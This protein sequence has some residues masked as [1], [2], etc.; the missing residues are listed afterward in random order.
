MP[1]K[2]TKARVLNQEVAKKKESDGIS[3]SDFANGAF[4]GSM[5]GGSA[6]LAMKSLEKLYDE[7]SRNDTQG[8]TGVVA[9]VFGLATTFSYTSYLYYKSQGVDFES[10]KAL[11]GQKGPGGRRKNRAL[12][13][14]VEADERRAMRRIRQ[15]RFPG[16]VWDSVKVG[17]EMAADRVVKA[18]GDLR[19]SVVATGRYVGDFVLDQIDDAGEGVRFTR[20]SSV[21]AAGKVAD[22]LTDSVKTLRDSFSKAGD[23]HSVEGIEERVVKGDAFQKELSELDKI[24]QDMVARVKESNE[25]ASALEARLLE[26]QDAIGG[27]V[28]Q[29]TEDEMRAEVAILRAELEKSAERLR[30]AR[31]EKRFFEEK[32]KGLKGQQEPAEEVDATNV[33]GGEARPGKDAGVQVGGFDEIAAE[34]EVEA[35]AA[36]R[37]EN[38]ELRAKLAVAKA[39]KVA[40]ELENEELWRLSAQGSAR[41]DEERQVLTGDNERLRAKVEELQ[42]EVEASRRDQNSAFAERDAFRAQYREAEAAKERAEERV[43]EVEEALRNTTVDLRRVEGE[44]SELRDRTAPARSIVSPDRKRGGR[45]GSRQKHVNMVQG[46]VWGP[47]FGAAVTPPPVYF[48]GQPGYAA[49]PGFAVMPPMPPAGALQT[50]LF[51]DP[52]GNLYQMGFAPP[53]QNVAYG[54]VQYGDAAGAAAVADVDEYGGVRSPDGEV[55]YYSPEP[56]PESS[57]VRPGS[58]EVGDEAAGVRAPANSVFAKGEKDWHGGDPYTPIG[59]NSAFGTDEEVSGETSGEEAEVVQGD[60]AA[61]VEVADDATVDPNTTPTRPRAS[62]GG[63]TRDRGRGARGTARR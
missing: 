1:P 15:K 49:H 26:A 37:A 54:Q 63:R 8:A 17:S 44:F 42:S 6:Y 16:T 51:M 18:G 3:K 47:G 60:E 25:R 14:V 22:R 23:E 39:G 46:G 12:Q 21:W 29:S 7:D 31:L 5:V 19:D 45:K 57:P 24:F 28:D 41:D 36:V 13:R 4:I 33:V 61:E 55:V 40:A 11:E 30:E 35:L 32:F 9:A 38:E 20:D 52:G 50:Q 56:S 34:A 58:I 10:E 43:R 59:R 27:A 2:K 62:R 53:P 48:A